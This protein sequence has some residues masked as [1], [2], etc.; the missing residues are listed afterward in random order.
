MMNSR[1]VL[2][3]SMRRTH[4]STLCGKH[5][6]S[7]SPCYIVPRRVTIR[8]LF[9]RRT[10]LSDVRISRTRV[11]R[12]M[13]VLAGVCVRRVNSERGVRRCFGGASTR[14]HRALHSGTQSKLAMRGV[15]RGLIKRV[16][17]APTR[18]HHCFGSLPRSDV[19]CVPARMRIRVVAL[20]P[21]VPIT[22]VRSIGGELHSCAS[23]IAG[24]RVS[25]SALTHLCS[26]SGTST[27]GNNRYKFVKHN[28]VSPSCTG[29][30]FDLRSPGGISG[31]IRSRFNCRVVRLVRGH[32]SHIGA[33]RVLLHPGI[34]RG[35][36]ARTYTHLSSV[37][38]S[39]H[40]GGFSFSRTTT[41]V[42]R[43][44]S[45]HGGRNVVIGVGRGSKIAASG[46]RVRSLPRSITGIMSGVGIKRV[47]GT[48]AVVG[49]GSKGRIYTV[50]GLGTGVGNRG[51]AVTRSCRSLG[52]VMVS[53]HHR[54]VLRG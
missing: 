25:F 28:V 38:S 39:V 14:V 34:S 47:S 37:T 33:H 52:R 29:I 27:V 41:I 43:S 24:K 5:E 42:S 45:A 31:V 36:L 8:G 16:G 53:G 54:R 18:M 13:S 46:F 21:G 35:R 10:G 9:L 44:G 23:H 51:T 17:M 50:I 7:N 49:R 30:T 4:V 11:V 2:G 20:R 22:R 6:F 15:R 19:P 48:F 40:T 3:S 12:Q 32:N 26:R 1:T